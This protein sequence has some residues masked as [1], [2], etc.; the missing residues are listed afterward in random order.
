MGFGFKFLFSTLI[1]VFFFL[2]SFLCISKCCY[3]KK[4]EDYLD[5][6]DLLIKASKK[7]ERSKVADADPSTEY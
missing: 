7:A 6:L 5:Q 3:P 1:L 2:I 4:R